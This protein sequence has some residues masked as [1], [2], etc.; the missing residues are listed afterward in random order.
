[1]VENEKADVVFK[2]FWRQ[3]ERFADLFNTVIFKGQIVIRPENLTEMDTDVSGTIEMKDYKETLTRTR[4]V[5]KKTAYG[6]EF[7]VMGV[8]NQEEVHYAMPL[9]SMI[10]DSLGYLKEYKEITRSRKK[11]GNL[12]TKA[13]FLSKMKKEDRLHPVISL[14]VY[15]GENIWDGPYCLKDMVIEMPPEI[16]AVFSDYK[17]NLLEV[18]DSGK[19]LFNNK[20]VEIVF[21]ITRKAF[22][23]NIDEIQ[24]KYEH[25]KLSSEMLLVIG[26]M[27]GSKEIMEMGNNKEV[28]SM[29]TAL[30]KL[31]QQG[32]EQGKLTI[33]KN[34]L[35]NGLS[36]EEVK[37]IAEVTEEE[38]EKAINNSSDSL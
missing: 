19:Y 33:I 27:T 36:V 6:I 30:E 12:R 3:N 37:K 15:Y 9:R 5:V 16:E 21:D 1:M 38:I 26:K 34:L 10:Y 29:C 8:E 17:M 25:E 24:Q 18:R 22:A 31:K 4:D 2:E 20:E 28:D 11:E 32:V 14:I 35:S 7:V 23:G 13:E